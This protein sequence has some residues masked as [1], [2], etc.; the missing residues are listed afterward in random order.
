MTFPNDLKYTTDHEWIKVEGNIGTIG[1][2]DFAQ[3]ELGDIVY[4]EVENLDSTFKQNQNFG[5][6]DAVKTVSEL[7][8]PLSGNIIEVN[9]EV[10]EQAEIIN[11]E[12]YGKGWIIKMEIINLDEL[13]TLL[14]SEAYKI[15]IGH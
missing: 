2:T 7:F 1:I 4:V 13:K 3:S 14:T 12:P 9:Q 11:Q 5:S 8:M 15:H 6:I 10:V